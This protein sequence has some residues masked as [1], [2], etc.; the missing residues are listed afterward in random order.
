MFVNEKIRLSPLA[1]LAVLSLMGMLSAL[2]VDLLIPCLPAIMNQ[3]HCSYHAAHWAIT[4]FMFGMTF[5]Q[6]LVGP[7]ADHYGRRLVFLI[8]A[9]GLL[10]VTVLSI[11]SHSIGLLIFFRFLEAVL[12]CAVSTISCCLATDAYSGKQTQK[13]FA[14]MNAWLALSPGLGPILSANMEHAWHW[15]SI[16]WLLSAVTITLILIYAYF[17]Q[18]TGENLSAQPLKHVPFWKHYKIILNHPT[19]FWYSLSGGF[20]FSACLIYVITAPY[21]LTHQFGLSTKMFANLFAI[22]AIG[23]F[24]G[25]LLSSHLTLK[26]NLSTN[27]I[28]RIGALLI[29]SSGM[30][31]AFTLHFVQASA[32]T[33]ICTNL[34]N[35]MGISIVLSTSMSAALASIKKKSGQVSSVIQFIRL[36]MASL[37]AMIFGELATV[38]YYILP[39]GLFISGSLTLFSV[40]RANQKVC[41]SLDAEDIFTAADNNKTPSAAT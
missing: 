27:Q 35:A 18:E 36:L 24:V 4:I 40:I 6:L 37:A 20:A 16:L 31:M 41:P 12:V 8:S 2:Y 32:Y 7:L 3:Y 38:S 10:I 9:S 28:T 33:V 5:S 14:H 22:N 21:L 34:I 23:F 26:T 15:H 11:L 39:L 1:F 17:I 13:T 25:G 30:L 29:L 19:C